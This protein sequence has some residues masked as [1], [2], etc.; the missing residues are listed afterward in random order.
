M[1]LEGKEKEKKQRGE[2]SQMIYATSL[3]W[4]IL[5]LLIASFLLGRKKSDINDL[6]LSSRR[7]V[8]LEG[9]YP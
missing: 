4:V 5:T 8:S 7:E 2:N 6:K 3:W 1:T 9:R